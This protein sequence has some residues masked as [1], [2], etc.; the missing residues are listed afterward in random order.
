MP[1]VAD[2]GAEGETASGWTPSTPTAPCPSAPSISASPIVAPGRRRGNPGTPINRAVGTGP[3]K[4][5]SF[6][7]RERAVLARNPDH[8]EAARI[9]KTQRLVLLPLPDANTRV[10]ALRSGQ[11]DFIEAPPPDA[12]PRLQAAGFT[13]VMNRTR[14]TGP[15]ISRCWRARPGA[16]SVRKAANLAIDRAGDEGDAG[17]H[18]AGGRRHRH[19]GQ[20]LVRH[21]ELPAGIRPGRARRCWPRPA[22]A[23][24]CR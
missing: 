14:I 3:W 8:W 16:T 20:R 23:R 13:T 6:A 21:A 1:T 9:P 19:A 10:A 4:L 11:V 12:L 17:R 2:W 24:A 7:I 15:G 5:E 18:H 22:P